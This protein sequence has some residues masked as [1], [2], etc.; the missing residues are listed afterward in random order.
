MTDPLQ[1]QYPIV[2]I[3]G[4]GARSTY[5]PVHYFYGLS[6]LLKS[7]RNQI[8]IPNLTAWQTI[9]NRAAQLKAQIEKEFP[10]GKVNLVGHSMGGLDARYLVSQLGFSE[11]VASVTTL[12]TPHRGTA[13]VDLASN[14][15]PESAFWVADRFLQY[16][17]SN[18]GA[19]KQLTRQ[20]C[21]QEFAKLA[22]DMPGVTYFSA[23]TAIRN[24]VM[25]N[26]LPLFW[27]PFK[28]V[29]KLEGENDGF[30]SVE[31][32]RWGEMICT[33]WGDHYA[34]IGQFLGRSRGLDYIQFYRN[35]FSRLKKE[36]F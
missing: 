4:L 6:D 15:V 25:R 33:D 21:Q 2:L 17:Q 19:F 10:E 24:P 11:R 30:V 16:F 13:A 12:G 36:G 20:Y 26:A 7:S 31:S 18:S 8:F 22:P 35:I 32:A 9:E 34:Q 5:G 29:E 28:W 27:A 1:L 14:I 23:T 3:H